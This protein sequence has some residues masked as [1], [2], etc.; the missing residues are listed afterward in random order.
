MKLVIRQYLA[1]LKER[2]ELDALL[3]DLL[4]Q[5]GLEVFLKPGVGSR[6]YGVD[7][8]AYG[9]I[10]GD[11][12]NKVYL[13]SVKSGDLDRKDWD[14]GNPQDL[15]PSINEIIDVF[16]P[17][18]IPSEYKNEPVEICLCFGGDVKEEVRA[19]VSLF[20]ERQKTSN[21]SFSEWNGDR[22]AALLEEFML[23][24]ELLPEECRGLLRK[25]LAM[26]D[27]PE[28]SFKHFSQLAIRL[29]NVEDLKPK[30]ILMGIRQL[31]LC[32]WILYSWS[33]EQNNIESAF[34]SAEFVLLNAWDAAKFAFD[35]KNKVA[36]ST[37]T[38]L[39]SIFRLNLQ[40]SGQYVEEKIIPHA[41]NLYALS[42]AVRPS[43]AVD[44]NL[45]LFDV[46]GRLALSGCWTY[47]Y[48]SQIKD[49]SDPNI[50]S[51]SHSV[52]NLQESIKKLIINNPILFSPYKDEQAIDLALA[53]WFLSLDPVHWN[54]IN[55]WLIN[56]A[57]GI[58][59]AFKKNDKYP[60][61]LNSYSELIEH[62]VDNSSEYLKSVTKG[63]V[64]YP[65][66]SIYSSVLGLTEPHKIIKKLKQEFL[67]HCNFQVFFFDESSEEH[68]YRYNKMHG[69]TLSHVCID[70]EPGDLI[71]QIEKE[72]EESN[73]VYEMSAFKYSFWPIILTGCRHYRLPIPT[74]FA[75]DIHKQRRVQQEH[76][77]DDIEEVEGPLK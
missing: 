35:K 30:Q 24:E 48:L 68:F 16:I 71:D 52:S 21:L 6:Q 64:L 65:V 70:G 2:G 15:R 5:M 53:V 47:W 75:M 69:A 42:H 8:G 28:T 22:L 10:D 41:D 26:I 11:S 39:D 43:C 20:L 51:L 32:L 57:D 25:S 27:E 67:E 1:S 56:V 40:I 18:R 72:C 9:K 54:D 44:V 36:V 3:P 17:S 38:T 33:R 74:Q 19:N 31:Y 49:E 66:I 14:S 4:S 76:S 63:S 77:S 60:S 45:K 37:L 46:L 29:T 7:V 59:Q 62:P 58:Y 23:R 73:K 13:F 55:S 50:K 34:L 61:T 12:V